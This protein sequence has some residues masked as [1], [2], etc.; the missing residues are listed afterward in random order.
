MRRGYPT[1]AS[2]S[3]SEGG[4]SSDS[5][6]RAMPSTARYCGGMHSWQR[7]IS[8]VGG[9]ARKSTMHAVT[10]SHRARIHPRDR[11][12]HTHIRLSSARFFW[13]RTTRTRIMRM[14]DA[15]APPRV[16]FACPRRALT[17][18][19]SDGCW[20]MSW[21][22]D[23]RNGSGEVVD[24]YD[25]GGIQW[26]DI[27]PATSL[28]HK[29]AS[30]LSRGRGRARCGSRRERSDAMSWCHFGWAFSLTL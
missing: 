27:H 20:L 12:S 6:K 1:S 2:A 16:W 25:C 22:C 18:L 21:A 19:V 13:C 8:G 26:G 9:Q 11:R 17:T 4:K 23:L 15:C 10:L 3:I 29:H 7:Q 14:G 5:T 28:S 24:E 30:S